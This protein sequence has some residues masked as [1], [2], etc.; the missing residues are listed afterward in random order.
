MQLAASFFSLKI[1][2]RFFLCEQVIRKLESRASYRFAFR[3]RSATLRGFSAVLYP[4]LVSIAGPDLSVLKVQGQRKK[5]QTF[6]N[7]IW[8]QTM[9][10]LTMRILR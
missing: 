6:F 4:I 9:L 7:L 10:T 3:P 5:I 1:L 2:H 8:D